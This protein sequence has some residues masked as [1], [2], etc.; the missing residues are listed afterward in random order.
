MTQPA[1]TLPGLPQPQRWD[2]PA[3]ASAYDDGA[4]TITAGP[5]SDHFNDPT[6]STVVANAPRLL[7][8]VE[9]DFS[10]WAEVE[11]DFQS[12]FDAGVLFAWVD[13]NHYA[14]LCFEYSPQGQPMI[15]SVVTNGRS[16]DCNSVVVEGNK[17]WLRVSR[18]GPAIALH[19]SADGAYWQMVRL[20]TLQQLGGLQAG[21][22]SQSPTGQGC[23]ATFRQIGWTP[24]GVADVRS[25]E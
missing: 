20:C 12:T 10:L 18:R 24:A 4:L 13:E 2:F 9:G 17:A 22:S 14:K 15:V 21:F 8:P 7:F 19:W 25:G 11:V 16:D 23:T 5:V 3:L 6:A 1:F